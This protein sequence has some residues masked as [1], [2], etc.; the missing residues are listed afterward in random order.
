MSGSTS[1]VYGNYIYA[2]KQRSLEDLDSEDMIKVMSNDDVYFEKNSRPINY[3]FSIE[4]SMYDVVTR[5]ML[6]FFA[7]VKD[8]NSLIGDSVN[9]Y[10]QSYKELDKMRQFYFERVQNETIDFEKYLEYYKWFD[11]AL[12]SMLAQLVPASARFSDGIR[13]MV[14]SHVLE[15]NKYWNKFPMVESK[16]PTIIAG[17]VGSPGVGGPNSPYPWKEGHAPIGMSEDENCFWWKNRAEPTSAFSSSV[18]GVNDDRTSIYTTIVQKFDRQLNAPVQFIAAQTSEIKSGQNSLS[19]NHKEK[20][21]LSSFSNIENEADMAFI[22][23]IMCTSQD[24]IS[25]S[26]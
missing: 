25:K 3:Y 18:F 10:R 20:S 21:V 22:Q 14:N 5:Q 2:Q 19:N 24:L 12:S 13:T 6:E 15:R 17:S 16:L 11:S 26:L 8:F 4:K 1:V 23:M 7:T 9:R